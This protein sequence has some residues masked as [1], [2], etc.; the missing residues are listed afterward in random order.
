[1]YP[2][3][4]KLSALSNKDIKKNIRRLNSKHCKSKGPY[5]TPAW[6]GDSTTFVSLVITPYSMLYTYRVFTILTIRALSS[7]NILILYITLI[8]IIIYFLHMKTIE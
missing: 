8:V 2:G 1:M 5:S 7:F 3:L 4:Q 6:L